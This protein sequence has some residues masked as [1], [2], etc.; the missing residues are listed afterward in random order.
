[1]TTPPLPFWLG[2]F[3]KR[4]T[5]CNYLQKSVCLAKTTP[6]ILLTPSATIVLC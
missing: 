3:V 2:Y 1:M 5:T 4:G 6:F